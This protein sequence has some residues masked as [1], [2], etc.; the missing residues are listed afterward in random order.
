MPL[1]L[2]YIETIGAVFG[3]I[4]VI[5]T[6]KESLWCWP[7]GI[8]SVILYGIFYYQQTLYAS[9]YLQV[10][11]LIYCVIGWYQW[12]YGGTNKTRLLVSKTKVKHL[13]QLA[14]ITLI[15]F[16]VMGF[17]FD[18]KSDD[19]Q[20]YMDS[21][22]TALSFVA[23]WMMNNKLLESWLLWILADVFYAIMHLQR[24][25][26]PSFLMYVVLVISAVVGYYL[27]KKSIKKTQQTL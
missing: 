10:V 4:S 25:N 19:D 26:Y 8:V 15:M 2:N 1:E 20:P 27:W 9:M 11:Y 16:L 7:T 22:V 17:L 12:L 6:A 21:F 3:I 23:Q 5:L 13:W 24:E 18:K 14:A